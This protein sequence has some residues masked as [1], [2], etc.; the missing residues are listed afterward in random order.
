[1]AIAS[2]APSTSSTSATTAP[3]PAQ[4]N[5]D[6]FK[7]LDFSN[8]STTPA[9]QAATTTAF[10]STSATFANPAA[11]PTTKPLAAHDPFAALSTPARQGSPFQYQQ[12]TQR[13]TTPQSGGKAL[14][15]VAALRGA[16][17]GAASSN[18]SSLADDEWN[19]SSALPDTA[20]EI[21][22]A[23]G[24][25]GIGFVVSRANEALVIRS[26]VSNNTPAAV[27]DFTFQMAVMKVRDSSRLRALLF[28][29]M[30]RKLTET[31]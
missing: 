17:A 8:P 12:S 18:R 16:T 2:Q 9:P 4:P 31:R 5:Y 11:A 6:L 3:R 24:D 20:H 21:A 28:R 14:N 30:S 7:S 10:R 25:V 26:A 1:M 29:A 27:G 13:P 15:S 23:S 19:F 22:V